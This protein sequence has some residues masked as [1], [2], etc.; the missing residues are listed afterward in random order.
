MYKHEFVRSL[1]ELYK[2]MPVTIDGYYFN[3]S[4]SGCSITVSPGTLDYTLQFLDCLGTHVDLT[5]GSITLLFDRD[6]VPRILVAWQDRTATIGVR[7]TQDLKELK[8]HTAQVGFHRKGY[9]IVSKIDPMATGKLRFS[10]HSE[11]DYRYIDL[12]QERRLMPQV[13][14][15]TDKVRMYVDHQGS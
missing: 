8:A 1:G 4:R 9:R 5:G 7:E 11:S 2:L 3:I 14:A 13:D 10:Y 15:I 6:E 12:S